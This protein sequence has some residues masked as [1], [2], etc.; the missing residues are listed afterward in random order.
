MRSER[1]V[2]FA[3]RLAAIVAAGGGAEALAAHLAEATGAGVLLEDPQR[4]RI[5]SAGVEPRSPNA[6]AAVENGEAG[7]ALRLTAGETH[8]GW[9][10]VLDDGTTT[11]K[12]A[13]SADLALL[14]R[15]AAAVI[16]V[17]LARRPDAARGR[18]P[19]WERLI[20]RVHSDADAIREDA[21][22]SGIV[23]AAAYLAIA[24]ECEGGSDIAALRAAAGGVF[25]SG[26]AEAGMLERASTLLV[27]V[28]AAREIDAS[29]ARTAATLLPKTVAKRSHDLHF[30]GGVGTVEPPA[31]L[32]RSAEAA[33]T[34]LAIG[35]RVLGGGTC[36][37]VRCARARIRSCTKA[38]ICGV[39][40]R[41]R[42]ACSCRCAS[43]TSVIKRNSSAPCG[44]SS[45]PVKT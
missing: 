44:F 39:C 16:A 11:A 19:F 23:P 12:R 36:R 8:V 4:R 7:R 33:R 24:L 26:D 29:N 18:A 25:R 27:F 45:K 2:D 15:L 41:S 14:A 35:R 13:E 38:P 28:P 30:S 10:R 21:S 9:L 42:A 40:R 17:E 34:A 20:D 31:T 37:F 43:T 5:A 3:E 22:A 6:R 1:I 32:Y